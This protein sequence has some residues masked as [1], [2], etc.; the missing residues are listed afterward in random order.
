MTDL[1]SIKLTNGLVVANYSSPHSF[2][3]KDG[4]VL[5]AC[6]DERATLTMLEKEKI[7]RRSVSTESN[8]KYIKQRVTFKLTWFVEEDI[9]KILTIHRNGKLPW[10]VIITPLPVMTALR[11]ANY[12]TYGL[13][14]VT[15]TLLE[16]GDGRVNKILHIDEFCYL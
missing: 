9:E 4:S 6:S 5:K 2:R 15:G 11:E 7:D 10:D 1:P 13:P 8:V 16:T 12:V 3:F 14:F